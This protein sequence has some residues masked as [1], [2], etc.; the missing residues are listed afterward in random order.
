V[1]AGKVFLDVQNKTKRW[2]RQHRRSTATSVPPQGLH[3]HMMV[4]LVPGQAFSISL[5]TKSHV[6]NA[7]ASP[8]K[9]LLATGRHEDVQDTHNVVRTNQDNAVVP[10]SA[11][12]ALSH[13]LL[14]S[15]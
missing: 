3:V 7:M 11:G 4:P 10:A 14:H 15:L 13:Q 2:I 6:D 8:K 9:A 5:L 1:C 12:Q